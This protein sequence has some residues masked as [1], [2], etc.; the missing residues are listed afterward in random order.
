MTEKTIVTE[1]DEILMLDILYTYSFN[2]IDNRKNV[3][4]H[5]ETKSLYLL[6][7]TAVLLALFSLIDLDATGTVFAP[8]VIEVF[9]GIF[10]F[11]MAYTVFT[12]L[13]S[14]NDSLFN[15][16]KNIEKLSEVQNPLDLYNLIGRE[17]LDSIAFKLTLIASCNECIHAL[18]LL[19]ERKNSL[20]NNALMGFS[21]SM[22]TILLM[23]FGMVL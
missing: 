22:A 19:I 3:K 16:N 6:Q 13:I 12:L 18:D 1:K 21:L 7:A 14:L 23:L 17:S 10:Y 8:R 5:T 4:R 9:S 20:F 15:S 11:L 2:Q